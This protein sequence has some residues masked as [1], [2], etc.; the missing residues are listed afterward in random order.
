MR[1]IFINMNE[2]NY[3]LIYTPSF[4]SYW[5]DLYV[6]GFNM[7][8]IW[9]CPTT[10]NLLPFFTENFSRNHLDCGVA[11]GYFPANALSTIWRRNSQQRLVLLDVNPSSLLA[12]K[13]RIQAVTTDT[14]IE[15]IEADVTTQ[16]TL[17]I[18]PFN[19]ISMFNLF[20]CIPGGNKFKAINVFAKLLHDSGTLVGCTVLGAKHTTSPAWLKTL[21]LKIYNSQW[22]V[23]NN[24]D[25][26]RTGIEEALHENF[27]EVET[28]VVGMMLLFR[29]QKP[30]RDG[31]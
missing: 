21:Y 17:T 6:L 19:S 16:T 8:Y 11:T 29:A 13:L 31:C 20:H 14:E 7:K 24:W 12:A 22:G 18:Q 5:Y 10:S 27:E 3:S 15:C 23:F 2:N 4:L 1:T 30:R 25:D 28:W 26:S 9:G